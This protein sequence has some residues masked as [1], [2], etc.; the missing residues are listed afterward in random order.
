MKE[1]EQKVTLDIAMVEVN[2]S[3]NLSTLTFTSWRNDIKRVAVVQFR[4]PSD[5]RYVRERLDEIEAHWQ[6]TLDTYS[7]LNRGDVGK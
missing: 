5:V 2:P 7:A 6:K 4:E 1:K 3:W